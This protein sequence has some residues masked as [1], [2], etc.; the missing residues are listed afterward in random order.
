VKY[1]T[2][3]ITER[4]ARHQ[5]DALAAAPAMLDVVMLRHP[6]RATLWPLLA[7]AVFI[8]SERMGVID[9]EMIAAAPHLRMI[10]RLGSL[11]YDIDL[12]A[13]AAHGVA[14]VTWPVRGSIMV[15]EHV[16][17][18]LLALA[19]R[20]REVERLALAA[21]AYAPPR[22]TDENTFAY[23]WTGRTGIGGLWRSTVGILGFGEIG[24]ELARRLA[25]WGC[26][27]LYNRRNR[28]PAATEAELGITYAGLDDL[29]AQ[30]DFVAN[31]LPYFPAT[32]RAL[33]AP[34]FARMKRG[35]CLVS[36]GSGSVIDEAALAAAFARGHLGGVALDTYEWEPLTP[37]NPLRQLAAADPTANILLTPHTAAGAPAHG[38]IP[39]RADDYTPIMD[40]LR[41][42]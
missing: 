6:D 25:G 3:F 14:V 37:D 16:M 33:A 2:L 22:R 32:D 18:Q 31:L 21:G 20:L 17:M 11:A 39:S 23:N 35:A 5:A 4:S 19:K 8:I 40:F 10:V 24:A 27:V 29:L 1:R 7:D 30:S 42:T 9:A 28:L 36:C 13:A 41:H 38:T 34:Q 15:A 26:T 12:A